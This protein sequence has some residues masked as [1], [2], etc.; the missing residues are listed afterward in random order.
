VCAVGD[1]TCAIVTT[2]G[3]PAVPAAIVPGQA[4]WPVC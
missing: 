1:A 3:E 2:S 4:R